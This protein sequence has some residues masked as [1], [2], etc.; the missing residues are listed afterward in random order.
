[1][2]FLWFSYGFPGGGSARQPENSFLPWLGRTDQ[3]SNENAWRRD[4]YGNWAPRQLRAKHRKTTAQFPG[5]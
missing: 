4:V 1:M 2:V 3:V 5:A